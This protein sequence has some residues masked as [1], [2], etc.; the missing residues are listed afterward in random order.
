[1]STLITGGQILESWED[2]L[3][4]GSVLIE[5]GRIAALIDGAPDVDAR[6]R[7]DATGLIVLPGFVNA[8]HHSYGNVLRGTENA[9]PLEVWAPFTVAW[10]RAIDAEMSRLAILIGAAEMMRSGITAVLDHSPAV[11]LHEAIFAAHVESGLRVGYA[12]FLQDVHDHN[13]LGMNIPAKLREFLEGP[14]FA[15]PNYLDSMFRGLATKDGGGRVHLM[16]GPNAPQ[17]CSAEMIA[18]W[19]KLRDELGLPVHTHLLETRAQ[20]FGTRHIWPQGLI[21]EMDRHG[22]LEA[23]M[24]VAHAIWLDEAERKLLAQRNIAVSHNPASNLMLGSGLIALRDYLQNGVAVGLGSDSANTGG[25]ADMFALMRLAMMLPRLTLPDSNAWPVEREVLGMA[26]E[27]GAGV[28]GREAELGRLEEGHAADLFL[29][30]PRGV[31]GV[32]MAPS[33]EILVQ[34]GSPQSVV[35]TMVAGRWVYRDGKVL[36][37]DEA[38]VLDRF[39][40]LAA[41]LAERAKGDLAIVR[42][43]QGELSKELRRIAP[44]SI[45]PW[46]TT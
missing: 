23:P 8:H 36:A 21:A 20:A 43:A 14:G 32:A 15:P 4:P 26:T 12:P 10:G 42:A 35:A 3:R 9:L 27:G 16:L 45:P 30:D 18:L 46:P 28:L 31:R 38:A 33:V 17:R 7:V 25:A 39:R 40:D 29:F 6:E 5:D 13:L 24:S 41:A 37:F 2:D 44:P 1:M 19:R 34:H 22:L 11:R